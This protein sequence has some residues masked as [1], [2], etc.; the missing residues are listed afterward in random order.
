MAQCRFSL[1]RRAPQQKLRT[2]RN[3][4]AY[5]A[6]LVMK[7]KIKMI[8]FLIFPSNGAPVEWNWQGKT[9]LLGEKPVAVP[10]CRPQIP[11]TNPGSNQGLH[12]GRP[13]TNRLSHGTACRLVD[14]HHLFGWT[15]LPNYTALHSWC[16]SSRYSPP[17]EYQL[18]R[19]T[20]DW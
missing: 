4:K 7:T 9:E 6:T 14:I 2:H 10:L 12:G 15:Y 17:C 20:K 3:L 5:C 18:S 13:A 1:W 11:W 8:S 16:L 19:E